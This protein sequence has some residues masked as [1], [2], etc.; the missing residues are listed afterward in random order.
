MAQFTDSSKTNG[1]SNRLSF[2]RDLEP[3]SQIYQRK[4][5][6]NQLLERILVFSSFDE[7]NRLGKLQSVVV[8]KAANREP[9][10]NDI[11]GINFSLRARKD[12]SLPAIL[13]SFAEHLQSRGK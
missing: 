3:L 10:G 4:L 6:A 12:V 9:A 8:M 2:L 7:A 1:C 13:A 5:K 11:V